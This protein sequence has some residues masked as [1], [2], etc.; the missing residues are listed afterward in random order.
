MTRKWVSV[1]ILDGE[2]RVLWTRTGFRRKN[3]V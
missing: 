1:I 3:E 2:V